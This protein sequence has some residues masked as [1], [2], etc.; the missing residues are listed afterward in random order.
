MDRT[1]LIGILGV[2]YA[3]WWWFVAKGAPHRRY[4]LFTG[5]CWLITFVSWFGGRSLH[6]GP[7]ALI[8]LVAFLGFWFF[9]IKTIIVER[10]FKKQS[11]HDQLR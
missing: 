7:L 2:V 9:L 10:K 8:A 5:M 11:P 1:I 3:I 6:N 4:I